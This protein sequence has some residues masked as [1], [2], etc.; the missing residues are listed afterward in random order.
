M[1]EGRRLRWRWGGFH[2]FLASESRVELIFETEFEDSN[3]QSDC[4]V[5]ILSEGQVPPCFLDEQAEIPM[6]IC[7]FATR[8]LIAGS[9]SWDRAQMVEK[10]QQMK[11]LRMKFSIVENVRMPRGIILRLPRAFQVAHK[12]KIKKLI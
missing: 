1:L 4:R 12:A 10:G 8:K 9:Q 6:E 2:W 3:P 11:V 5:E 7:E